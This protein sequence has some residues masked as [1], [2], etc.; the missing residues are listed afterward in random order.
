MF[1]VASHTLSPT[2][3]WEE[4]FRLGSDS[5]F[6]DQCTTRHP[7]FPLRR[8]LPLQEEKKVVG[9]P[10]DGYLVYIP[11]SQRS[12]QEIMDRYKNVGKVLVNCW[13]R[14]KIHRSEEHPVNGVGGQAAPLTERQLFQKLFQILT[15][16]H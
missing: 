2:L 12:W 7:S 15:V 8:I 9:I 6:V 16:Y 13:Q 4:D 11:S 10:T 3:Y 14:L 1:L 5:V